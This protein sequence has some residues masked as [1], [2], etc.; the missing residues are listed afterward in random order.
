MLHLRVI[1]PTELRE[2]VIDVL[3]A[4]LAVNLIGIVVAGVLVLWVYQRAH[5]R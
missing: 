4:Q 2:P 1:A 3:T 5:A